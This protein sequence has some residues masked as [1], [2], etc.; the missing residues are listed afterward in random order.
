MPKSKNR[1]KHKKAV[2]SYKIEL[3]NKKRF[4]QKKN[5]ELFDEYQKSEMEKMS[6]DS[7]QNV[8][9]TNEAGIDIGDVGLFNEYDAK[10]TTVVD[11]PIVDVE[12]VEKIIENQVNQFEGVTSPEQL[13]KLP[14]Q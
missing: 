10:T 2:N 6:N 7:I 5:K 12:F 14:L 1:S 11:N 13:N 8:I 9:D 3:L 4:I